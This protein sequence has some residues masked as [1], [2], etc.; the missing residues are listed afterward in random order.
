VAAASAAR[1]YKKKLSPQRRRGRRGEIRKERRKRKET[2]H[3]WNSGRKNELMRKLL[4]YVHDSQVP[5][6]DFQREISPFLCA[7]CASAVK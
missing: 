4:Y 7:L 2:N 3:L 6:P 1:E 5:Y